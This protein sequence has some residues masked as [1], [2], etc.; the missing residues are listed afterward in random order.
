MR[1]KPGMIQ[2]GNHAPGRFMKSPDD[3]AVV[4]GI[5]IRASELAGGI[6]LASQA[7]HALMVFRRARAVSVVIR[8]PGRVGKQTKI[9]VIRMILLH[10]DN[11]VIHF[12]EISVGQGPVWPK[13]EQQCDHEQ[14]REEVPVHDAPPRVGLSE[15][16]I[17]PRSIPDSVA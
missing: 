4:V 13:K 17:W 15:G 3:G 10:H 16:W 7:I 5:G 8:S 2:I 9:V 11:D 1:P 14:C 6:Y 12:G